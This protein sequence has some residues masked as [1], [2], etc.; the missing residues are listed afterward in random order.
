M[1]G[2]PSLRASHTRYTAARYAQTVTARTPPRTDV[3]LTQLDHGSPALPPAGTRPEAMLP[4]TGP[5][6]Y[7]TSTEDSANAPPKVRL[8]RTRKP[9]LRNAKL[10]PRRTIPSA[11]SVRGTN[12]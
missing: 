12:R 5:K 3:G 6:Q 9:A 4:I 2:S 7:G 10:A 8:S 1:P 11:A